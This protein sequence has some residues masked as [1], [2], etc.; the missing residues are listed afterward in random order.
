MASWPGK[1]QLRPIRTVAVG[2]VHRIQQLATHIIACAQFGDRVYRL[3]GKPRS[4]G[5]SGLFHGLQKRPGLCA[6][7]V[8][9]V[10][11]AAVGGGRAQHVAGFLH[12]AIGFT[13]IAPL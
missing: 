4:F 11:C 1:A 13:A 9:T 2:V 3:H 8:E 6:P 10:L 5:G 12:T 7:V